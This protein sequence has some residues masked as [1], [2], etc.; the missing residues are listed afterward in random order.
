MTGSKTQDM[1]ADKLHAQRGAEKPKHRGG[2]NPV[3]ESSLA[4]S[5]DD[6]ES[7]D[8]VTTLD[9]DGGEGWNEEPFEDEFG[10]SDRRAGIRP[11]NARTS[12]SQDLRRNNPHHN[13]PFDYRTPRNLFPL[14]DKDPAYSYRWVDAGDER[15]FLKRIRQGWTPVRPEEMPAHFPKFVSSWG[16]I[17]GYVGV[18]DQ[19]V[20]RMDMDRYLGMKARNVAKARGQMQ[21]VGANIDELNDQVAAHNRGVRRGLETSV[22]RGGIGRGRLNTYDDD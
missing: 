3:S 12:R 4:I 16:K 17:A 7:N 5:P 22:T 9:A 1:V 10:R 15:N 14:P 13:A 18:I 11:Q 8:D 21:Q 20:M 19:V 2:K 6:F